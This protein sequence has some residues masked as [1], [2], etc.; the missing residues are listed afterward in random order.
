[1]PILIIILKMTFILICHTWLNKAKIGSDLNLKLAI[2]EEP[3]NLEVQKLCYYSLVV[4][5]KCRQKKVSS[6]I[7]VSI[8]LRSEKGDFCIGPTNLK[9]PYL[10]NLRSYEF[11][12]LVPIF[13]NGYQCYQLL[14]VGIQKLYYQ[15]N[16]HL[17][18]LFNFNL[19]WKTYI[20]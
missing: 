10:L 6:H 8:K 13:F 19:I 1:M 7:V 17:K 20:D 12:I 16:V 18:N 2:S 14:G 5:L 9:C 4:L 11:Q 15:R 3:C